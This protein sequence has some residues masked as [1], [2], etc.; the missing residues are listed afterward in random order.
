[1]VAGY[2]GSLE[3]MSSLP[4][5][6]IEVVAWARARSTF[7]TVLAWVSIVLSSFATL[8][9]LMQA[10]MF[11]FLFRDKLSI[12]NR[13]WPGQEQLPAFLQFIFSHPEVFFVT[14][15]SLT[16]LTFI[17]AIG[18]LRRKNWARLYFIVVLIFGIVWEVGGLWVQHK[19]LAVVPATMRAAPADFAKEFEIAGTVI[20]V[21]TT[22]FAIAVAALFGWLIKR[23][24]SRAV[25]AEFHAL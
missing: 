5:S 13:G 18:L 17:A 4:P 12:P 8:I 3:R 23:L 15:W 19:M 10:A 9:A 24:L 14:F 16:V 2:L 21:G 6:P 11:F 1:M 20:S 22:V 7:I 25:R